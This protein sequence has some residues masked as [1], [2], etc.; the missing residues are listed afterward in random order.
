MELNPE[1]LEH[2]LEDLTLIEQ[3]SQRSIQSAQNLRKLTMATVSMKQIKTDV[4]NSNDK[5]LKWLKNDFRYRLVFV[6]DG[7]D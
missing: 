5:E 6:H 7:K 1:L 3:S 2:M 4:K